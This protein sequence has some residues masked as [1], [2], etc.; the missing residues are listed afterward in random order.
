[1]KEKTY[2]GKIR[3]S[4]T[5]FQD[6]LDYNPNTTF[7][8]KSY[9][10]KVLS[11]VWSSQQYL[12]Q[13]YFDSHSWAAVHIVTLLLINH[14]YWDHIL[15]NYAISFFIVNIVININSVSIIFSRMISNSSYG[16]NYIAMAMDVNTK[17]WLFFFCFIL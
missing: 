7:Q 6:Q 12:P 1:M 9:N 3:L 10:I 5:I 4:E 11:P 17:F 8:G 16:L 13:Q 14:K 2:S 15:G